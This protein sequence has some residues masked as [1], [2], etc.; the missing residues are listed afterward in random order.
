MPVRMTTAKIETV[1]K[2][3]P[4]RKRPPRIPVSMSD[5]EKTMFNGSRK[6]RNWAT[7]SRNMKMTAR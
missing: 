3:W 1:E 6:L 5:S 4:A 2:V 7:R